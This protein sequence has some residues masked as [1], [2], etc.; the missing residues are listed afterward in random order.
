MVSWLL[1]KGNAGG[2]GFGTEANDF[3]VASEQQGASATSC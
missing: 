1:L 3:S 2:F